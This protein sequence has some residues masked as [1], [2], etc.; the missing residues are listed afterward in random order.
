MPAL[1]RYRGLSGLDSA[2]FVLL[3]VS[4]MRHGDSRRVFAGA[5][6]LVGFLAKLAW[7]GVTGGAL[8]VHDP[9]LAAVP[10]AHL[11]GAMVGFAVGVARPRVPLVAPGALT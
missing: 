8:F 10:V 1:D 4:L 7:E 2:L 6:A 11:A 5:W 3:A 9:G